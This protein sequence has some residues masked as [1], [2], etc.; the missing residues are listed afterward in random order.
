[1][2]CVRENVVQKCLGEIHEDGDNKKRTT[3]KV[4]RFAVRRGLDRRV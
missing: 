1:M 3:Q 4:I 2:V